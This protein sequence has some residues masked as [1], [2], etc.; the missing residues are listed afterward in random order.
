MKGKLM[1]L[2]AVAALVL[3]P[4][5]SALAEGFYV[6]PKVGYSYFKVES[7]SANIV[8]F[9][10]AVGYD[11]MPAHDIPVRAEFEFAH[12][13]KKELFNKSE[14]NVDDGAGT[15]ADNLF[16]KGKYG[17]QTFFINGYF[18]FHNSSPVTP[19]VGLGLG[20]ARVSA[21]V[22]AGASN[23]VVSPDPA[24]D[25]TLSGSTT[26]TNFAWNIGAGAAWKITD[27]M[28]LDLG[29]RYADFGKVNPDINYTGSFGTGTAMIWSKDTS[30][31]AHDVMLGLRISF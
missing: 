21:E 27:N 23:L 11:F 5:A 19:Y 16:M 29:Y 28:A 18:D 12:R 13:G 14:D 2:A 17:A 30:V 10:L 7:E 24:V 26:K 1:V 9:G 15:T 22:S 31:T 6:T 4:V 20:L 25:I 3:A 8:P